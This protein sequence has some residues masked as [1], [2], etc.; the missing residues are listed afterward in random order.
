[1]LIHSKALSLCAAAAAASVGL[2][3]ATPANAQSD[4]ITVTGPRVSV[5]LTRWV[6]YR[7]LN[8]RYAQ[9]QRM[10]VRRV[11][12]AVKQVCRERQQHAE[13]TLASFARYI[14]CRDFA[15]TGAR[16]QLARAFY[17]ARTLAA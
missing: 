14:Q 2:V 15:W 10:L 17:R 5:M 3:G 11:G 1:M 6:S 4:A 7:D 9:H 8:L 16:P 12:Y 13:N